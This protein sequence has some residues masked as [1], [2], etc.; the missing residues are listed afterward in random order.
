MSD[1]DDLR[2][3]NGDPVHDSYVDAN[4][5]ANTGELSDEDEEEYDGEEEEYDEE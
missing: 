3:Y 1:Y 2:T 5:D 4:Y